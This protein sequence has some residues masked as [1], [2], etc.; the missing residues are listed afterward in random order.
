M[1]ARLTLS[2]SYNRTDH[3]AAVNS[4]PPSRWQVVVSRLTDPSDDREY[5]WRQS[6]EVRLAA[7]ETMRQVVYGYD[8]AAGR[9][10]RL[11]ELAQRAPR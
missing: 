3:G 9:L 7:L 5:W 1:P 4:A 10:Q 2:R 6:P 11:L 8:P